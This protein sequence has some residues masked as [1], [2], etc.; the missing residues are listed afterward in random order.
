[1]PIRIN[2]RRWLVSAGAAAGLASDA[3]TNDAAAAVQRAPQGNAAAPV[4]TDMTLART[5][6]GP[7]R[8]FARAGV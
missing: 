5:S 6:M 2:R 8:G 1:M 3:L 7:V 4:S